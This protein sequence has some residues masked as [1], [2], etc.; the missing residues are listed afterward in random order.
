MRSFAPLM[1]LALGLTLAAPVVALAQEEPGEQHDD[2]EE[3]AEIVR[4]SPEELAEFGIEVTTAG[5]GTVERHLSLPGEV[6]PNADQL[7]HIV[8]RYSGIVVEVRAKI[9]DVV[10]KGQVLAIIES[11]ESLN[12]YELKTLIAGTVIDKHITLGEAVSRDGVTFVIADLSSVWVDLTV[13]Q[14]DLARVMVGQTAV[15]QTAHSNTNHTGSIS[16][17]TPVV[18]EA[19]RTATA[20][21][22]LPNRE[23]AWRPGMFVTAMV[24]VERASVPVA[25]PRTAL[26]TFEGQTVV[27]LATDEGFTP[28]SVELGLAGA[29]HVEI[30]AGLAPGERYVSAGGFTVK[31]ELAKES[32]SGGHGH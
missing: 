2:H 30:L 9:G 11:D 5:P 15:I 8:P 4:L 16:Y 31:A 22:V 14:R 17:V 18:D 24:L 20:R 1:A 25:V 10:S 28:R 32:F 13:Y 7:A 12:T 29:T 19:T 23:S 26:H 3:P 27:F 6:Q 21:V